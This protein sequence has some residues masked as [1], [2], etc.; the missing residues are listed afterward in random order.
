MF[1]KF[2]CGC[3]GLVVGEGDPIIIDPCD[4][5]GEACWEPI[6]FHVRPMGEKGVTPLTPEQTTHYVKVIDRLIGDGY[7]FR[8]M[9]DLLALPREKSEPYP[10]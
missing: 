2:D 1:Y 5:Q 7:K 4:L 3:V 8:R 10:S 9:R 6:Q